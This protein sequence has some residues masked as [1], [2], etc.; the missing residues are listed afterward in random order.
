MSDPV[1]RPDHYRVNGLECIDVIEALGLGFHLA[2]V[3]KYVWRAGR[4]DKA[5]TLE[6]LK[7]ARFYLD[8]HIE[9]LEKKQ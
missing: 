6:D 4:K 9:Q 2:N 7:K 8:R 5:K 1:N 3:M